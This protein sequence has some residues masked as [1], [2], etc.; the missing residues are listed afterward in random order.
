MKRTNRALANGD[1]TMKKFQRIDYILQLIYEIFSY[2]SKILKNIFKNY[3]LNQLIGYA[4][5]IQ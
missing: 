2:V 1:L 5:E 3:L 4:L